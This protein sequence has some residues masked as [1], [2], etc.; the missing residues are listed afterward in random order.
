MCQ[1][2]ILASSKK[3]NLFSQLACHHVIFSSI[4]TLATRTEPT[5]VYISY[6]SCRLLDDGYNNGAETTQRYL[7]LATQVRQSVWQLKGS[8]FSVASSYSVS[9]VLSV[10]RTK[11]NIKVKKKKKKNPSWW[12]GLTID[13]KYP[14]TF[15]LHCH[16][17]EQ[18]LCIQM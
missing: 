6:F 2:R 9:H 14:D 8:P 12:K 4:S 11:L 5:C 17:S 10:S 18:K 13:W 16:K 1:R 7:G 15:S 3:C